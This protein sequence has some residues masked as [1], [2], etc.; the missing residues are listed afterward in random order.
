M[1]PAGVSEVCFSLMS[2]GVNLADPAIEP[3]DDD[4]RRLSHEAFSD[5]AARHREVLVRLR[6]RMASLRIDALARATALAADAS[7]SVP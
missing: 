3:S 1:A 2:I 7:R 6:H 5:V 4:L